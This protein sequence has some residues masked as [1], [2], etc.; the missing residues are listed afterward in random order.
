M[1][2]ERACYVFVVLPGETEFT[3]AGRFRVSTTREGS[4]LGEFVYGRSYLGRPDAVELDPVELRLAERVYR[5][6]RMGG[7]F[8]AIRDAMPDYWGRL[9][10]ERRSGGTMPGEFDYLMLGPDDRAGA[11]GFGSRLEP[12][13]PRRRFNAVVDLSGLQAAADAVLADRF[14]V[15]GAL[16]DRARELLIAGTSMGGARPKALVE[17]GEALWIAKFRQRSD[18]WNLPRVEHGL[19]RLARRCGLETAGSRVERIGDRDALLVRRFDR[20][21][22]GDGYVR[23]RMA[24]ALTLLRADDSPTDRR[25]WSYLSLA[26]EVRRASASPREDLRELFGRMC[27]NAAVSNLD[28]HPR[29]HAMLA[30][31]RNWR[32]SP[33]Y[34]LEPMPVVAVE[35]RD[36]AMVCGPRGRRADRPN[37]LGAA[38]RFLLGRDEAR[39]IFNGVTE[40]IRSSWRETMRRAGVSERDCDRIRDAFLYEGLFADAG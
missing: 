36:L 30:R 12:P 26:D 18:R 9:L 11:L 16:A 38:G 34:D 3:V 1:T 39:A 10:I 37:L 29:N 2:S 21:W 24:S 20:E 25:R 17:D 5:T 31:G 32:L 27:F 19:L 4:P 23:H 35:R 6:G 28:D 33:A 22:T 14:E 15:T 7:F 13:R 8:G 40:T